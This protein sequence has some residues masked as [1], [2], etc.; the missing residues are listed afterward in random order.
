MSRLNVW[1]KKTDYITLQTIYNGLSRSNFKDHY[2][3]T[4]TQRCL[5]MFAEIDEFLVYDKMLWETGADLPTIINLSEKVIYLFQ[6]TMLQNT[7]NIN[8][9]EQVRKHKIASIRAH[10][11]L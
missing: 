6:P 5:G 4:A 1:Q 8:Y 7:E 9:I 10:S 11:H 2:G 3:D